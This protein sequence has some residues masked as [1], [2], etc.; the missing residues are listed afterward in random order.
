MKQPKLDEDQRDVINYSAHVIVSGAGVGKSTVLVEW[1][2]R[3]HV[4]QAKVL[5][6]QYRDD[7]AFVAKIPREVLCSTFSQLAISTYSGWD[8]IFVDE[9]QDLTQRDMDIIRRISSSTTEVVYMGDP[10]QSITGNCDVFNGMVDMEN[11]MYL[12]TNY[13]SSVAVVETLNRFGETCMDSYPSQISAND[14]V[15]GESLMYRCSSPYALAANLMA[16]YPQGSTF[17]FS[18]EPREVQRACS[19]VGRQIRMPN[20]V[21]V[22]EDYI[23]VP[24]QTRGM[25][26]PQVIII[27]DWLVRDMYV[28]M[29]RARVRIVLINPPLYINHVFEVEYVD[30]VAP[31][32]D[33]SMPVVDEYLVSF[34]IEGRSR[35]AQEVG[36]IAYLNGAIIDTFDSRRT[37]QVTLA[38]WDDFHE[39]LDRHAGAT[40]IRWGGSDHKFAHRAALDISKLYKIHQQ[41]SGIVRPPCKLQ[42]AAEVYVPHIEWSPHVAVDDARIALEVYLRVSKQKEKRDLNGQ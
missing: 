37:S 3:L 33:N 5:I 38:E 9:A 27:G 36:A 32:V 24:S 7:P 14:A 17:V 22:N 30:L 34:D 26:R 4:T 41:K 21:S 28:A 1:V 13:R 8:W 15:D 12:H 35:Q 6:I 40:L 18:S 2:K 23:M 20:K 29:S 42:D 16:E 31:V 10:M 11:P 25:E 39:W 19:L